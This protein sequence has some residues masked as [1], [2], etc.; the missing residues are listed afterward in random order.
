MCE[1]FCVLDGYFDIVLMI[2]LFM[3]DCCLKI[4]IPSMEPNNQAREEEASVNRGKP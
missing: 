3:G 2:E 1:N 4:V